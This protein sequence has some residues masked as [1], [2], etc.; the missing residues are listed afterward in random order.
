MLWQ[1]AQPFFLYTSCPRA[2]LAGSACADARV[3]AGLIM[4]DESDGIEA[5]VPDAPDGPDVSPI[6]MWDESDIIIFEVSDTEAAG[7]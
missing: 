6:V 7:F 2:T 3:V 1:A 5:D 4:W